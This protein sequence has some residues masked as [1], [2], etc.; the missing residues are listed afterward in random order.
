[1]P[2]I[3]LYVS[4]IATVATIPSLFIPAKPPTPPS[5]SSEIPRVALV[6][7][8]KECLRS[9]PFYIV[10]VTFSV[11]VGAFNSF[12]SLLNQILYPYA[13]SEDEAG[14]CGAILIVVGLV[15]AAVLSPVF[16]RTHAY[17]AGIKILCTFV[18][19]R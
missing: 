5:A 3:V 7:S 8:L 18:L 1:M 15:T 10:F 12:S 14:I 4:I 17:L 13:Y 6:P 16:D 11:Y 19:V 9:P 2:D